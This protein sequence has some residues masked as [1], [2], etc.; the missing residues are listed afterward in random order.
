METKA[1]VFRTWDD[2]VFASRNKAYGAY[3]LRR[4]YSRRLLL[5]LG[6]TVAFTVALLL[7]PG[8]TGDDISVRPKPPIPIGPVVEILPPPI[9]NHPPP[10]PAHH[11]PNSPATANTPPLVTREPVVD[12]PVEQPTSDAS[13]ADQGEGTFSTESTGEGLVEVPVVV[14]PPK[15]PFV[16][17][18]EIMPAYEGGMEALMKYVKR[19]LRYP[20]PARRMGI[21]GTVYV[22]FV[23]NGDGTVSHV[24]VL[25][26]IHQACDDEAMRVIASLPGWIGGKQGGLPVN[27]KMVLPIKFALQ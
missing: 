2:L 26:G 11:Q 27:V 13:T 9:I 23:V 20:S 10:P 25:R 18:A 15:P 8:L 6:V 3:V 12:E 17:T 5:G 24:S 1:L 7:L 4:A 22:S 21:D 14:A 19:N 16:I